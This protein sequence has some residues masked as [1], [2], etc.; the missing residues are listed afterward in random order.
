LRIFYCHT[1]SLRLKGI[2]A[3]EQYMALIMDQMAAA[4]DQQEQSMKNILN[5]WSTD[6]PTCRQDVELHAIT[7]AMI[8]ARM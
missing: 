5:F 2:V 4:T 8:I 7:R 6:Y 1:K 3:S